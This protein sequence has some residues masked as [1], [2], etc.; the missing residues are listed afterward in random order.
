MEENQLPDLDE[1]DCIGRVLSLEQEIP[2]ETNFVVLL[3]VGLNRLGQLNKALV[4][5]LL[6]GY[7]LRLNKLLVKIPEIREESTQ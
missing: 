5:S 3:A 6:I 4:P 1:V 7:L 2:I